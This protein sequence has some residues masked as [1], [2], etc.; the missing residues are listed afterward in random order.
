[1]DC[2]GL[3]YFSPAFECFSW[4]YYTADT[5][6]SLHCSSEKAN[7]LHI[8]VIIPIIGFVLKS[9]LNFFLTLAVN[10][11]KILS[12]L[13]TRRYYLGTLKTNLRLKS[14]I[15]VRIFRI[16]GLLEKF[17]I[18]KICQSQEHSESVVRRCFIK[19][20]FLKISQNSQESL[21][22]TPVQGPLF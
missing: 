1:M 11:I 2:R 3:E 12:F 19:K 10:K 22:E 16:S 17:P 9:L 6:F 7:H 5:L 20:V 13:I 18:Y 8:K 21:P 15:Q 4:R 14:K